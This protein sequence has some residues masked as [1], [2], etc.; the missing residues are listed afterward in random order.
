[1]TSTDYT[2]YKADREVGSVQW[3]EPFEFPT[4]GGPIVYG[5]PS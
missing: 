2:N 1:M 4:I 5:I 3:G